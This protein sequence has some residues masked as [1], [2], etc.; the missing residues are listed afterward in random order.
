MNYV[1]LASD[2]RSILNSFNPALGEQ[3]KRIVAATAMARAFACHLNI[4]TSA[5]NSLHS[6]YIQSFDKVICDS[7]NNFNEIMVIDTKLV[8][9]L[10]FK[11]YKLRYDTVYN[12]K[13]LMEHL[14][15]FAAVSPEFF[16]ANV[17]TAISNE[18]ATQTEREH[19]FDRWAAITTQTIEAL[20]A[21]AAGDTPVVVGPMATVETA[22]NGL[23]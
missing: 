9:D 12:P 11:F 8:R 21:D 7:L 13:M 18:L 2:I 19:Y 6:F 23:L 4:P 14:S 3:E 5:V 20:Q 1:K 22:R 15:A 10:I 16:P 17:C